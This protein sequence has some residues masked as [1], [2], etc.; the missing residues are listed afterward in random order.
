M[1][2]IYLIL[3]RRSDGAVF[4]GWPETGL[5]DMIS[6]NHCI[7]L[8][9]NPQE[10]R[11]VNP[12]EIVIRYTFRNLFGDYYNANVLVSVVHPWAIEHSGRSLY[13]RSFFENGNVGNIQGCHG[14]R[15]TAQKSSAV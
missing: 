11:K 13:V 9:S 14:D 12:T 10:D 1:H 3:W 2:D 4:W 5:R 15:V 6:W 8:Y 7:V